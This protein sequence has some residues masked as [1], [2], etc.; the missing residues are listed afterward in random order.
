MR[1]LKLICCAGAASLGLALAGTAAAQT[2]TPP[3][4]APAAPAAPAANP[5]PYPSMTA[6]LAANPQPAVFDAGPLGKV[7]VDGV[8]SADALWQSNPQFGPFGQTQDGYADI[9]NAQVILNKT[10]GVFQFYVQAGAYS[11]PTL[12][13]A[14]LKTSQLDNNTLATYRRGS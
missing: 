5:M 8:L 4:A 1:N 10:D 13:V 11:I 3:A 2:T 9:T 7:M 6:P 12:G 14:Y